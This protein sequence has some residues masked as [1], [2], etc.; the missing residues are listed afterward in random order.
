VRVEAAVP[1]GPD[2]AFE[3]AALEL[4]EP[5]PDEVLVRTVAS[6]IC[7]ADLVAGGN[8]RVPKP[9]VLGHEGAGIVERVGAAVSNLAPGD[10]VV[11]SFASCGTCARC[12][13]GR[14]NYCRH[15]Q[16]LRFG[17]ARLDGSTAWS[18]RGRP[19][20]AHFFRPVLS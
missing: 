1:R 5:R 20:A 18:E 10:H 6:G 9:I 4:G 16:A 13:A 3:L 8:P 14:P 12:L 19:M 7:H 15:G 2:A 17:G 11:L